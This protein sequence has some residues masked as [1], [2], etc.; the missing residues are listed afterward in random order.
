MED[1]RLCPLCSFGDSRKNRVHSSACAEESSGG[2]STRGKGERIKKKE[3]Q[4]E[5]RRMSR[6]MVGEHDAAPPAAKDSEV[7]RRG[8][9][10]QHTREPG[11]TIAA[12]DEQRQQQLAPLFLLFLLLGGW[13]LVST[14][15]TQNGA[16]F[17]LPCGE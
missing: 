11:V 2:Q 5:P 12:D 15:S 4:E 14:A 9:I 1:A 8:R 7:R 17:P 13:P 6:R 3:C 16:R 10:Q